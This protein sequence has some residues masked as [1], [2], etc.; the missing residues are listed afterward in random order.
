MAIAFD[1]SDYAETSAS[2]TSLDVTGVV[3]DAEDFLLG[4]SSCFDGGGVSTMAVSHSEGSWT[5]PAGTPVLADANGGAFINY[6]NNSGGGTFTV[7]FTPGGGSSDIDAVVIEVSGAASSAFDQY[8]EATGTFTS[9][10]GGTATVTTGTLAQANNLI[11]TVLTHNGANRTFTED[12][13]YTLVAED[14][15]NATSQAF[16]SQRITTATSDTGAKTATVAL[17]TAAGADTVTWAIAAIVVKEAAAGGRTTK[18]TR[19]FPL[20]M[21]IGMGWR[22]P[23]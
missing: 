21:E 6:F 1:E 7:T 12:A 15:D 16:H 10:A 3:V 17:G 22:M 8:V 19:G 4:L 2:A 11:F 23:L 18:N 13:A 5:A 14:E 20:G 9:S